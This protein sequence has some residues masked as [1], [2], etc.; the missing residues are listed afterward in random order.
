[1]FNKL[2]SKISDNFLTCFIKSLEINTKTT[3][4]LMSYLFDLMAYS[5]DAKHKTKRMIWLF[6]TGHAYLYWWIKLIK[7]VD[8][9]IKKKFINIFFI[10]TYKGKYSRIREEYKR[11]YGYTPPHALII[12]MTKNC[13]YSCRGCW[14]KNYDDPTE[15]SYE[16]W[17][18]IL[19]EAKEKMGIFMFYVTG[20]EPFLRKDFL[21]L[22][23]QFSDCL[24]F[25]YTN[26]SLLDDDLIFKIK[27]LANVCP[28]ISVNGLEKEND[29]IRGQGSYKTVMNVL[30]KLKNSGLFFGTSTVATRTNVDS[31][32]SQKYFKILSDKGAFWSWIFDYIPSSSPEDFDY[33]LTA[34]NKMQI[35]KAVL[36][37]R[38]TLPLI[39]F[40]YNDTQ[41]IGGCIAAGNKLVH[42]AANG[43]VEP[44]PMLHIA[45]HNLKNSSLQEALSSELFSKIRENILYDGN[46]YRPC[47]ILD[48]PDMLK[49]YINKYNPHITQR[50][51]N[52]LMYDNEIYEKL[53][54]H[55]LE[56]KVLLDKEWDKNKHI[57]LYPN[58]NEVYDE[59]NNTYINN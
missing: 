38:N 2:L 25:T 6:K 40:D 56:I 34:E 22:V 4:L 39:S 18:E 21:K 17:V 58:P 20:G 7:Q 23:E 50:E 27:K 16:K 13:N 32:S 37:A 15:L 47:L 43:F 48:H 42:I 59:E 31:I 57:G 24:F 10:N 33:L 30:D 14:A 46:M 11:L 55:S 45:Q 1:M 12:S 29:E 54:N 26:A 8:I 9:N 49:N 51:F 19:T 35:H 41:E 3:L 52:K 44:C 5:T 36:K 53:V 28:M